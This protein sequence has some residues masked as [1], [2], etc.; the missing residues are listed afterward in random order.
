MIELPFA[1]ATSRRY[2]VVSAHSV[3]RILLRQH[4]NMR[5]SAGV[6]LSASAFD[7]VHGTVFTKPAAETRSRYRRWVCSIPSRERSDVSNRVGQATY[8]S[9]LRGSVGFRSIVCDSGRIPYNLAHQFCKVANADILT[10]ATLMIWS[11]HTP[12]NVKVEGRRMM[13]WTTYPWRAATLPTRI[14]PGR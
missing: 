14:R 3:E 11:H 10:S 9:N 12:A 5:N 7:R 1:P 6:S 8:V 4:T 13:P 2:L